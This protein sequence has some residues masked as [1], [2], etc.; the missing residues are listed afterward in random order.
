MRLANLNAPDKTIRRGS[1]ISY[2]RLCI[3]ELGSGS[4][5][6]KTEMLKRVQHL[7]KENPNILVSQAPAYWMAVYP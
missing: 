3:P 1:C 4:S 2:P 6:P 5:L 7:G